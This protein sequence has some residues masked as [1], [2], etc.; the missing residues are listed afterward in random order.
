MAGGRS[1]VRPGSRESDKRGIY[2]RACRINLRKGKENAEM[3]VWCWVVKEGV[4]GLGDL[5]R[6]RSKGR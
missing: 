5:A 3:R 1:G 4:G 6:P 2:E